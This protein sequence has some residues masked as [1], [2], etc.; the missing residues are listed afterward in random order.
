[1]GTIT[2]LGSPRRTG[3]GWTRRRTLTAGA[4]TLL[5]GHFDQSRLVALDRTRHCFTH[6]APRTGSPCDLSCRVPFTPS[7]VS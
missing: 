2:V 7:R 6:A 5:G 3:D 4:L 1:M